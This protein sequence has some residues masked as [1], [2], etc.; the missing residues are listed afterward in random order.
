MSR[1]HADKILIGEGDCR[2]LARE[3]PEEIWAMVRS[4]AETARSCPGYF[5]SIGNQ[6]THVLT[7]QSIRIYFKAAEELGNRVIR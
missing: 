5:M 6:I 2:I 1:K 7:P 4:M 3:D